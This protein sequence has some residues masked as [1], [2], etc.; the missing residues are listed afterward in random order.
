MSY[1]PNPTWENDEAGATPVDADSLNHIES[2]LVAAASVAD[3]AS[4]TVSALAA[5]V[6]SGLAAKAD[7]AAT[8][9][10]LALKADLISGK[11]PTSQL[12]AIPTFVTHPVSSQAAMLALTAAVGDVAVRT[13]MS[14]ARYL[15]VAEP[16]TSLGNWLLLNADPAAA[17]E[18]VNGHVGAV[19]LGYA[20]VG[21]DVAGA[22]AAAVAAAA[23]SY[24]PAGL[25]SGT[26]T[27]LHTLFDLTDPGSIQQWALSTPAT[28]GQVWAYQGVLY[29]RKSTGTDTTFIRSNWVALG[30]DPGVAAGG[31][32]AATPM[33]S[34]FSG[35]VT[36][37]T[38]VDVTGLNMTP[39]IPSSG[40]GCYIDF[41]LGV[42]HS[43]AGGIVS[44]RLFDVTAG[45][46]AVDPL[47]TTLGTFAITC[48]AAS[49]GYGLSGRWRIA[50]AG[51]SRTYKVQV[52]A[53]TSSG[54]ISIF[55]RDLG[56]EGILTA[57]AR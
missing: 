9:A 38:Y 29:W 1:T 16:A 34:S 23:A 24:E 56:L 51:G 14:N 43:V 44:L 39:V 49:K 40:R 52:I 54:T 53:G 50:P 37:G 8:T 48:A 26:L 47:G 36:T 33:T 45:A 30:S 17:V 7:A 18:S 41:F 57:T 2:G 27:S 42:S 19:T 31:E 5:S 6:S 35:S 28:R 3:D 12:P 10:S 25:S 15:L 22:G 13:D 55:G 4:G 20:D 32:L 11:V 21:A 46:A